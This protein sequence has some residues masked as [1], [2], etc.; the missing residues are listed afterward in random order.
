MAATAPMAFLQHV[1][2]AP[3]TRAIRC[4]SISVPSAPARATH[5]DSHVLLGL[6]EVELQQLAMDMGQQKYRG[7]QLHHLL[8][9]AKAKDIQAFSHCNYF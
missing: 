7:K 4:R 1:C 8:Y 5:V 6:S 2:S 3:L 9:K